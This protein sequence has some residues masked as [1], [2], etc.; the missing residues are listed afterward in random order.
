[1]SAAGCPAKPER[2]G[3]GTVTA[4]N[5]AACGPPADPDTPAFEVVV[6][7]FMQDDSAK[8]RERQR[9]ETRVCYSAT[10][11]LSLHGGM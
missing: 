2:S 4:P 11:L 9:N 6:D 3:R 1:M 10:R 5:A 8:D 7:A